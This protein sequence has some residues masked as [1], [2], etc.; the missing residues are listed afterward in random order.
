MSAT[1]EDIA[2]LSATTADSQS[3]TI[4]YN[5][6]AD[7]AASPLSLGIY[8]SA[9]AKVDSTAVPLATESI[10][11][12]AT[13]VP[14]LDSAG[15]P[16]TAPG[17]H[18][19]TVPIKGGLPPDPLRPYVV[20]VANPGSAATAAD[21][22]SHTAAFR[23][24]VVAVITHGGLQPRAWRNAGPPWERKM[25]SLLRTEGYDE[26]IPFNWVGQSSN[27][28]RAAQEG[29][30][31]ADRI[32]KAAALF[33]ANEPV[34]L[35]VIGQGEGAVINSLA[36]KRLQATAPPQLQ[37]G[38][39]V[40][41]MLDPRSERLGTPGGKQYSVMAGYK[42]WVAELAIKSYQAKADDPLVTVPPNVDSAQVYYQRT[43]VS[44]VH[45]ADKV[46]Y[47]LWGQVPVIGPATY[48]DLTGPGISYA[49]IFSVPSWYNLN[50]V[51]GLGDGAI[52]VGP[53]PLAGAPVNGIA[54]PT[55]RVPLAG[56][57][58]PGAIVRVSLQ[59]GQGH[60]I[61]VGTTTTGA[62]GTWTLT[63]RPIRD[64]KAMLF[65]QAINPSNPARPKVHVTPRAPLG[66]VDIRV[67]K[68][69]RAG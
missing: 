60:R 43:P 46:Y 31:V 9:N 40:D 29:Y 23:K 26:V 33:P 44:M 2:L 20:V 54:S 49:G 28:G 1:A 30:R 6:G 61:P 50:V 55:R 7:G 64:G 53:R 42:G 34:D 15:N 56:T 11:A 25:A 22:A 21:P 39:V 66:R 52:N 4:D 41:T 69:Q 18:T 13:G 67:P 27:P 57:A 14:L 58:E 62:D 65:G 5:L 68:G 36:L 35:Q 24:H 38:Y 37:A 51:P 45:E 8:R 3:V 63:T 47:N 10:S 19:V 48:Y 16:A 32:V 59:R 12:P 17:P